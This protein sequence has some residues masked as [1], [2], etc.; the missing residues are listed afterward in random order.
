MRGFE[1]ALAGAFFAQIVWTV[2]VGFWLAWTR[3]V[4]VRDR[5]IVGDVMLSDAGWPEQ[6]RKASR[7]FS[8]QFELPVLFYALA[9]LALV[10]HFAGPVTAAA[11]WV[12]V[13]GRIAH[14]LAHC[15]TNEYRFRAPA[16]YV[17]LAAVLVMMVSVGVSL[18]SA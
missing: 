8:N 9:L 2:F 15:T 7:N 16:F 5:T 13:A 4:A 3:R 6:A 14:S 12:F 10:A 18:V 11:A 1:A 17:G